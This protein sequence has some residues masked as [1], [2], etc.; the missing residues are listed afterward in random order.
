MGNKI[1]DKKIITKREFNIKFIGEIKKGENSYL[2]KLIKD[3]K[4]Y[5]NIKIKS[6][7]SN[8]I[9]IYKYDNHKFKL[10]L[11]DTN[12][13]KENNNCKADCIIMEYDINDI[14]SFE[15]I[16]IIYN[17]KYKKGNET[18][19]IYLIGIK[20]NSEEKTKNEALYFSNMNH[21]KYFIISNENENH[22]KAFIKD[23][24]E[25]L[26]KEANNN[27]NNRRLIQLKIDIKYAL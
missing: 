6:E 22:I 19:L 26:E 1:N 23:L 8:D 11:I 2:I 5:F 12:K 16:K 3:S 14:K 4:K 21:L 18:N 7:K 27:K 20:N 17:E 25:N 10:N 13:N 15:E 24:L 9:I